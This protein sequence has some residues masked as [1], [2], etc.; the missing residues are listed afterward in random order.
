VAS[1]AARFAAKEACLKLFPRETA[2]GHIEPV[3]FSVVRDNYGAPRIVCDAR[4]RAVLDRHRIASIDLS[5][6]HDHVSASA[7]ALAQ[8]ATMRAPLAG[9]IMYRLLPFRRRIIL[10]N[11]R[12]AFGEDV[13]TEEIERIAQAHYAHLLR[14]F[15]EFVQFRWLSRERLMARVRVENIE[16]FV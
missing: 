12:Q 16:A 13:G 7:V 4:A 9:R 6:T 1:L 8:P 11:L 15:A 10:D 14:L 5:L 3:D 2:L